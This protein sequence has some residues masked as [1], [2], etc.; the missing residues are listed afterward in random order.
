[1]AFRILGV[2][3]GTLNMGYGIVEE[4][5]A[6]LKALK[7]GSLTPGKNLTLGERLQK[8]YIAL[9]QIVDE[10]HP[11]EIA[12]EEPFVAKNVRSA[13]AI[14]QAQGVALMAAASRSIPLYRYSPREI[15]LAVT[16]SGAGSKEQVKTMVEIQL[17][18]TECLTSTDASDALA[19]A[20][21]HLQYRAFRKILSTQELG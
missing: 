21:C 16:A 4:T 12:V 6:T 10:W 5:S 19:V 18:I 2:D 1:M 17:N 8:L 20:L 15:K 13:I 11:S 7:S 14:G 9:I 3:P